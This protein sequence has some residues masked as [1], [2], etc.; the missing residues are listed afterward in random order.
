VLSSR[1][2]PRARRLGGMAWWGDGEEWGKRAGG[3]FT[4]FGVALVARARVYN[5]SRPSP[6]IRTFA[7]P[8]EA[9]AG[10]ARGCPPSARRSRRGVCGAVRSAVL[11]IPSR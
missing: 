9:I 4:A 10:A 2:G 8:T 11:Q 3:L 5:S 1:R 6:A 7:P